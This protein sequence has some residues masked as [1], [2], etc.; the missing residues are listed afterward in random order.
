MT[1]ES[2]SIETRV[3]VTPQMLADVFCTAVES[4]C[5]SWCH[6]F[7]YIDSEFRSDESEDSYRWPYA[8]PKVFSG[9]FRFKIRF[10]RACDAE[11]EGKGRVELTRARV[12]KGLE[13]MAKANPYQFGNVIGEDHDAITADSLLQFCIFG[14]E[15]YG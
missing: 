2:F 13:A 1:P 14:E 3:E 9:N 8:D 6:L 5:G 15:V 11:G 10:D 12:K 7:E 4:P